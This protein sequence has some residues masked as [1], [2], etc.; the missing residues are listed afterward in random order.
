[1][2]IAAAIGC[3]QENQP[4]ANSTP[5][6]S[7]EPNVAQSPS[8]PAVAE[9]IPP[10]ED[11]PA[12][13]ERRYDGQTLAEWRQRI[14][15]LDP[16]DPAAAMAVRGLIEIAADSEAPWYSRRQAA[17]TLGRIGPPAKEAVPLFIKLLDDT[18]DNENATSSWAAKALALFGPVAK[19]ASPTLIA[20]L[21]DKSAR[22]ADRLAALDALSQIGIADAGIVPALIETLSSANEKPDL[23]VLTAE[24]LAYIGPNASAAVP[25]LLRATGDK[26]EN[27][28]R[29]AA[30]AIG[31]VGPMADVAILALAELLV[32]DDSAAVRDQAADALVRIGSS[33]T[34]LLT[35]LLADEDSEVRWR[36]AR[37]LGKIRPPAKSAVP[38]LTKALQDS[39]AEVRMHAMES[40]R[41]IGGEAKPLIPFLLTEFTNE[42]RQIRVRA[43]KLLIAMGKEAQPAIERLRELAE[44][45]RAFV[46]QTARKA[47]EHLTDVGGKQTGGSNPDES[48]GIAR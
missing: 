1:V 39:I 13:S 21:K 11:Q 46:R 12:E 5:P 38:P 9:T 20:R 30:A 28:R 41:A 25:A 48:N 42:D 37:S 36:A 45:E 8:D 3:G 44:D 31:A 35:R 19:S 47:L 15:D 18:G 40:L 7:V 4:Q 29:A 16:N 43:F 32:F 10:T 26:N 33:A 6:T 14:K 24:A 27:L 2:I 22:I 23:R 17:L 34:K